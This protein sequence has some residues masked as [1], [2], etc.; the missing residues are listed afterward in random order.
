[1]DKYLEGSISEKFEKN[2][3]E[4]FEKE[5]ISENNSFPL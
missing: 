2:L 1:L 4:K 3:L 5:L